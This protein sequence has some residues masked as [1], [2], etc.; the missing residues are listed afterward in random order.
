MK[1]NIVESYK[2]V[3]NRKRL[4]WGQTLGDDTLFRPL[5]G[6]AMTNTKHKML[7]KFVKSKLLVFQGMESEDAYGFILDC[8]ERLHNLGIVH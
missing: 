3:Q 4:R 7:I 2:M 6:L 8:Y 1:I 5:L